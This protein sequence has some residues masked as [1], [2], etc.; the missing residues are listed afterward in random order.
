MLKRVMSNLKQNRTSAARM[1]PFS[2]MSDE[3]LAGVLR[4]AEKAPLELI[5]DPKEAAALM[6]LRS[7]LIYEYSL[8]N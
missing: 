3:D 8:R 1:R 7:D 6:A 5:T 4:E 2:V